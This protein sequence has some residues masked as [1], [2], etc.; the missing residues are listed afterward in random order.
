MS[1]KTA[2]IVGATGSIGRELVPIVVG[3]PHYGKVVILHRRLLAIADGGTC[4]EARRATASHKRHDYVVARRCEQ[5]CHIEIAVNIVRPAV[6]QHDRG[7]VGGTGLGISD[8]QGAGI[9][10]L[11]RAERRVRPWLNLGSL[12]AAR[13]RYCQACCD[14]RSDSKSYSSGAQ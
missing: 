2:V 12:S 14:N 11:E 8:I 6:Q 3:S 7:T 4:Q 13:L 5:G 9:D 10:L 1:K